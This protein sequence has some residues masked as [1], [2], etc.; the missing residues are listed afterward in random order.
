MQTARISFAANTQAQTDAVTLLLDFLRKLK[1]VKQS[2]RANDVVQFEISLA[3][4]HLEFSDFVIEITK[5]NK[6]HHLLMLKYVLLGRTSRRV[7]IS[8]NVMFNNYNKLALSLMRKYIDKR[9]LNDEQ[10][11]K[12][13]YIKELFMTSALFYEDLIFNNLALVSKA[14]THDDLLI[15][16]FFMLIFAVFFKQVPPIDVNNKEQSLAELYALTQ[17]YYDIFLQKRG[18]ELYIAFFNA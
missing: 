12:T 4:G 7:D 14:F 13:L 17:K 11:T 16:M 6:S 3:R 9:K 8:L 2:L 5:G 1:E 10:F 18:Q 15:I